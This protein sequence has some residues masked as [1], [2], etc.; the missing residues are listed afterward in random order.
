MNTLVWKWILLKPMP[1]IDVFI[2]VPGTP[3]LVLKKYSSG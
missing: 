1:S 3:S 2:W